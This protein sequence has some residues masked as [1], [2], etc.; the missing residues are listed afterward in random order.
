MTQTSVTRNPATELEGIVLDRGWTVGPLLPRNP[1]A[2]GGTFCQCYKVKNESGEEAFLKALDFQTAFT[3]GTDFIQKITVL[4]NFE[5]DLLELCG[6]K[7]MDRVVRA[8]ASGSVQR[9]TNNPFDLVP[10]LI[11]EAATGDIRIH[12]DQAGDSKSIAWKLRAIHHVAV[13]L[14]QLHSAEIAHQ[15]LKP[16]NVLVF[17]VRDLLSVSKIADLGRASRSGFPSPYDD[18]AWAGDGSYAPPEIMYGHLDPDW[19]RRRIAADLY[20]L[21]GL[22]S[23]IF[24]QTTSVASLLQNLQL[25]FWPGNWGK[26]FSEVLP[27]L[28]NAFSEASR[29]FEEQIPEKLRPDLMPVYEM[30]CNPDP[31][32]RVPRNVSMNKNALEKILSR[33]DLLAARAEA[34]R[35]N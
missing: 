22:I 17:Y 25:P 15:D 27:Y 21:G 4:F 14:K 12:L 13:G 35:Y 23:F 32:K 3:K 31:S 34:G 9:D 30:L 33:L 6:R 26:S 29:L 7:G 18:D 16:S 1:K 24:V 10:Y 28:A 19:S 11:F 8:I 2:T 5:R 20:M